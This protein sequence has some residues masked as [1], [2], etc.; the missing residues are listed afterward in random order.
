MSGLKLSGAREF[1]EHRNRV[2]V[3]YEKESYDE[4]LT[5]AMEGVRRFPE[6]AGRIYYWM[7]T[8]YVRLGQH[9]N[10]IR[11]LER[12]VSEG[13]W[14]DED[15]LL[16]DPSFSHFHDCHDFKALLSECESMPGSQSEDETRIG[17][18]YA[19]DLF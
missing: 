17:C 10:A 6:Q 15:L 4:A 13:H 12:G 3:L 16:E 8:V 19:C 14:W 18:S 7:A 2:M 1:R 9:D 5:L 11:V